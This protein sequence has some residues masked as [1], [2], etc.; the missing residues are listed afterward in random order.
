MRRVRRALRAAAC[1]WLAAQLTGLAAAPLALCAH[2]PAA[3]HEHAACCPGVAPGQVCPMH[4]TREGAAKCTMRANCRAADA[5]LLSLFAALGVTPPAEHVAEAVR[6]TGRLVVGS[7]APIA[8]A[9]LPD[10]PPPRA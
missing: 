10:P 5:A 2:Q 8:R 9:S 3:A 4:R 6:P 1:G 7:D